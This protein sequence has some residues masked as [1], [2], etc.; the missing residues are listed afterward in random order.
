MKFTKKGRHPFTDTARKRSYI[1]IRQR[2]ER[3]KFPLFADEI[4]EG[5]RSQD[6]EMADRA[7]RWARAEAET[8]SG[9][10]RQWIIV[11]RML[12][13]LPDHE[14]HAFLRYYYRVQFPLDGGYMRSVL[15]TFLDGRLVMVD[16][17]VVAQSHLDFLAARARRVLEMDDAELLRRIQSPYA[18]G[19]YLDQLRAER[20]R[21]ATA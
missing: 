15:R 5:Q 20:A 4:A 2:K 19:D 3:E 12:K 6:E 9:Y 8:R 14:R 11:R 17:E 16:G 1:L 21:R 18:T 13:L 7:V 10:A